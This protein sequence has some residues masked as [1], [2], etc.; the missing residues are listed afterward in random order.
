MRKGKSKDLN[1]MEPSLTKTAAYNYSGW[2]S[3][4]RMNMASFE[5]GTALDPLDFFS[6]PYAAPGVFNP[7]FNLCS[8]DDPTASLGST[9]TVPSDI[10]LITSVIDQARS[11]V[12]VLD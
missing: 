6:N 8:T 4:S 2:L 9:K 3:N 12:G 5:P 7:Y 10:A 1:Y 11:H